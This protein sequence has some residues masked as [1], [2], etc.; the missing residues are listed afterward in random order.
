MQVCFLS[1]Q[2]S[3]YMQSQSQWWQTIWAKYE[4]PQI[5]QFEVTS[6][7]VLKLTWKLCN[8]PFHNE[9]GN[10]VHQ[11]TLWFVG[12]ERLKRLRRYFT[13]FSK[14]N[15]WNF[16]AHRT[17]EMRIWLCKISMARLQ[18]VVSVIFTC[19]QATVTPNCSS[20]I[21]KAVMGIQ[22]LMIC[23]REKTGIQPAHRPVTFRTSSFY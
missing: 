19:D 10:H 6:K 12:T 4:T 16:S 11:S 5:S 21:S 20:W 15:R 7:K 17:S 13:Y 9:H 22:Y 18:F 23:N 8:K 3:F 14:S 1:S 2:I